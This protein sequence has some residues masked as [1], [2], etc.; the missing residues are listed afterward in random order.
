[1]Q[2][3]PSRVVKM[4]LAALGSVVLTSCQFNLG[5]VEVVDSEVERLAC[6]CPDFAPVELPATGTV[7]L[8]PAQSLTVESLR[9]AP[10]D[11]A[12]PVFAAPAPKYLPNM[13]DTFKDEDATY[14]AKGIEPFRL[15]HFNCEFNYGGWHN[16]VMTDYAATHGFN[17]IYPYVRK[18]GESAHL[19]EGTQLLSW[20]GFVDWR[21]WMPAHGM[22][23]GRYDRLMD[24]DV[25]K[26]LI[27]EKVFKPGNDGYLMIDMEHPCFP[28]E[29][30]RRESW[31]PADAA[32]G[33]RKAFEKKYYDGYARTYTGAVAAA[34]AAGWGKVSLYGWQPFGRTWGGLE[35]AEVDPGDDFAWNAFGREIYGAVDV[36]HS[37]V[38]CFYWDPKNVAYTL[39][40]IDKNVKLINSESTRKP[41]RPYYWTL[42]HGGGG[43]WRWWQGQP[44]ASEEQRAMTVMGFFTG[45]DGFDS[46]NWSGTDSHHLPPDFF[47]KDK[48]GRIFV[49]G[50]DLMIGKGSEVVAVG[51]GPT[52]SLKRYDIVHVV[53]VDMVAKTVRFQL[54]RSGKKDCGV[55]EAFPFYEMPADKLA[56]ILRVS[57]EPVAAMIE[58]M[59]LVKPFEA[60]LRSG[61]VKIDVPADL[62]FK[63]VLPIVRRVKCGKH[64]IVATYDPC[65]V[66]GGQPREITLEN[67]D[68]R[69]GLT[70]VLP[71]DQQTRIF[72]LVDR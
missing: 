3:K 52:I 41:L 45:V 31:Y 19:P 10:I 72:V 28:P 40:N 34:R 70:V 23:E 2:A 30:L 44:L 16:Y 21:K 6:L 49:V 25:V 4:S 68:G 38:Y 71:A 54:I 8:R 64:N 18:D 1:M 29:R 7:T 26:T 53:A 63:N 17:I 33:A 60:S 12:P 35:K 66:Y 48:E 59:A 11:S 51:A 50:K 22:E 62:Q 5:G 37:S 43:G 61:E 65:V 47:R 36:V 57:S 42:L 14:R 67:F 13:A 20:G 55:G 69:Q 32:E 58:G 46:W 9:G 56:G 27:D 39:A 15:N 24:M